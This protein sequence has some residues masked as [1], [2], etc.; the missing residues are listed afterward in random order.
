[1]RPPM[2]HKGFTLIE[3]MIV[4]FIISILAVV[5][6]PKGNYAENEARMSGLNTNLNTVQGV[7]HALLP[8]YSTTEGRK[9]EEAICNKINNQIAT[10]TVKYD[11][12]L[13]S[14]V[15]NPITTGKG[16]VEYTF[17][18]DDNKE[19]AAI[20]YYAGDSDEDYLWKTNTQRERL[21]GAVMVSVYV[22]KGQFQVKLYPFD[23]L[24]YVMEKRIRT[25]R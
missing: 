13:D 20:V 4:V 15:V 3:L 23:N 2:N 7:V 19:S 25:V 10:N 11:D 24:G 22:E 21:R 1:M 17:L 9:L 5:L 8:Y 6:I 18:T 16:M 12:R 14:E